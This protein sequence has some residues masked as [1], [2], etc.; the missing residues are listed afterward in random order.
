MELQEQ[1]SLLVY[2]G[3]ISLKKKN[4]RRFED[5]LLENMRQG[6]RG[7]GV[8]RIQRMFGRIRVVPEEG[9]QV[10]DIIA[11][12]PDPALSRVTRY[13]FEDVQLAASG[14]GSLYLAANRLPYLREVGS[15]GERGPRRAELT[16]VTWDAPEA[17]EASPS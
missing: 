7:L 11:T 10:S 8:R 4:R 15:A 6:T 13:Y 2:Y 17:R 12:W 1:R 3:E 16:S 9:A 5:R 14:H